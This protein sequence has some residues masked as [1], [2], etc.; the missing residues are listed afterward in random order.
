MDHQNSTEMAEPAFKKF[1][2]V[3]DHS[4]HYYSTVKKHGKG[5]N[6]NGDGHSFI[7]GSTVY[8]NI[9]R[10]WK[11]LEKNLPDT[12]YVRAY[13]TRVDLM[14]AVIIGA[15]DT[16]YQDG[17]FFFDIKFPPDYPDHPPHVYYRSHGLSLN[18]NLGSN[19]YICLSLLNTWIGWRSERWHLSRSTIL[20]VLVSIQGLVLNERPYYNEAGL[21]FF[22]RNILRHLTEYRYK[23]YNAKAFVLTCQSTLYLLKNPPKNFESFIAEHFRQRASGIL[24]A[25]GLLEGYY[26]TMR[27]RFSNGSSQYNS[28]ELLYPELVEAFRKNGWV[29]EDLQVVEESSTQLADQVERKAKLPFSWLFCCLPWLSW[30]ASN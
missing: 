2:I 27:L 8:K 17:L 3:S 9:M 22:D 30:A 25:S 28:M 26:V 21:G 16:P 4:D 20:Q 1:D 13:E 10:E 7:N 11:I 18:P 15:A 24:R 14:R 23:T 5:K 19:G 12:I 29:E 6:N